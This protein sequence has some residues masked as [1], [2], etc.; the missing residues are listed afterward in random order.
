MLKLQRTRAV[1]RLMWNKFSYLGLKQIILCRKAAA[2]ICFTVPVW[3]SK[4]QAFHFFQFFFFFFFFFAQIFF[5]VFTNLAVKI[6]MKRYD[7]HNKTHW[8]TDFFNSVVWYILILHLVHPKIKFR[9]LYWNKV[10]TDSNLTILLG[11][12]EQKKTYLESGLPICHKLWDIEFLL[13]L[14]LLFSLIIPSCLDS[15]QW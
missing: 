6:Y 11:E 4:I 15:F 3:F 1:G 9:I 12:G 10:V 5:P 14:L 8:A 2:H 7:G 13:L